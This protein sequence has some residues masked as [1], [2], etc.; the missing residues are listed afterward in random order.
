MSNKTTLAQRTREK[1]G[2][3]VEEF[4]FRLCASVQTVKGWEA[5]KTPSHIHNALL[6]YAFQHN[7]NMRH[8]AP[9]YFV[10]KTTSQQIEYIMGYYGESIESI[11]CRLGLNNTT[12]R[13]W[14][15]KNK[16]SRSGQRLLYEVATHPQRFNLFK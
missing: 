1:Y 16:A 13:L 6:N 11:S 5:G 15:E 3:T 2:D 7:L 10:N 8:E 12:M 9:G 14:K 4:A